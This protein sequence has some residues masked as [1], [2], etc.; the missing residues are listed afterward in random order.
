MCEEFDY[1]RKVIAKN[2]GVLEKGG[3]VR[4][5][6]VMLKRVLSKRLVLFGTK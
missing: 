6:S 3:S 1:I 4:Q 2:L 5:K